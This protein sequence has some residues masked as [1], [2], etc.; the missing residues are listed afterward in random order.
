MNSVENDF[1]EE[2]RSSLL[3][4]YSDVLSCT[5]Q[6]DPLHDHWWIEELN[7]EKLTKAKKLSEE[8]IVVLEL[9]VICGMTQTEAASC[10]GITQAAF[11][12]KFSKIREKIRNYVICL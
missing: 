10:L 2:T 3:K 12:Q 5:M 11:S 6:I 7:N 9:H 4:K 1:E 8:E